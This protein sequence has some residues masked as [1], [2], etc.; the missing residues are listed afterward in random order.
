MQHEL[1]PGLDV[2]FSNLDLNLQYISK[3]QPHN[4]FD[5]FLTVIH[6]FHPISLHIDNFTVQKRHYILRIK[7]DILMAMDR[8]KISLLLLLDLSSAFDTIEHSRLL[9][10]LKICFSIVTTQSVT[11]SNLAENVEGVVSFWDVRVQSAITDAPCVKQLLETI[12]SGVVQ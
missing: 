9:E 3:V 6:S 1:N 8:Q 10:I 4:R 5:S 7:S 12:N 2:E 11:V